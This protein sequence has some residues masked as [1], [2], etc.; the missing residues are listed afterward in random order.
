LGLMEFRLRHKNGSEVYVETRGS[1][2]MS[3][4][5]PIAFQAIARD[6]TERKKVEERLNQTLENLHKA[7]G[8]I[9]R[10]ISATVETRDPYT[11]GHQRRVAE[12][13]RTIATE[14][15]LS[16]DQRD[17]LRMAG[18]IHDLGKVSI[19]AE[20]LV[21]PAKLS[22]IEYQLIQAH[23]QIGYDILKG[24]EFPWP[25]AEMVL[26]H[27]ERMDG[28]GYPRGLKG[29]E[30]SKEARILMVADVVEAMAS[31]RPYRPALGIDAA[32][33]EI[34]KNKGIL[35]DPGV[36]EVCLSLFREKGFGFE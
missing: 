13:A 7:M 26:Q 33:G 4:G 16:D 36:V 19:P 8:G 15:D 31:Y 11:A 28:S 3:N 6:I 20:I 12:L 35:Y 2:I 29:E 22:A 21:K 24:I 32:L 17:G 1:T 10:V 23:S 5:T 9:I 18:T 25:I 27:H 30:I 34:E 14:M